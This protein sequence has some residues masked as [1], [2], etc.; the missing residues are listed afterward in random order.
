MQQ[1]A[2]NLQP[3]ISPNKTAVQGHLRKLLMLLFSHPM[4]PAPGPCSFQDQCKSKL[5]LHRTC[6]HAQS[7][8][9]WG[10]LMGRV[11]VDW[12]HNVPGSMRLLRRNGLD[13]PDAAT[14]TGAAVS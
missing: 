1:V 10:Q 4:A 2:H 11:Q 13:K 8:I 3:P 14:D 12:V 7:L 5:T 9:P 6:A